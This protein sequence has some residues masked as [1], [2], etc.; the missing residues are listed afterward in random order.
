MIKRDAGAFGARPESF[1]AR[2]GSAPWAQ[3]CKERS[4]R[5]RGVRPAW[6]QTCNM[7]RSYRNE[8]RSL[9]ERGQTISASH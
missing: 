4:L 3:T 9:R 7:K 5:E 1:A 6:A 2:T 8:E